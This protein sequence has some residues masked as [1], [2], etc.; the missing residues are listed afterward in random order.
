MWVPGE[1]CLIPIGA[2]HFREGDSTSY[3]G[4]VGNETVQSEA[5][6]VSGHLAKDIVQLN[7]SGKALT[8]RGYTFVLVT[9]E[10]SALWSVADGMLVTHSSG[11]RDLRQVPQSPPVLP[12]LQSSPFPPLQSLPFRQ[13]IQQS[14][15]CSGV[16][17]HFGLFR[18]ADL[19][20]CRRL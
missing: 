18:P 13:P 11:P 16:C 4:L 12:V 2:T 8:S 19:L 7:V 14:D 9:E 6:T 10:T 15:H 3:V 20:H 1:T 17:T 5:A